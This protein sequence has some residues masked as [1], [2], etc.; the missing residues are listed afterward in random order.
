MSAV[1]DHGGVMTTEDLAKHCSTFEEAIS[2]EYKGVRL[3]EI[4]P[5]TQGIVALMAL[6]MLKNIDV[7]GSHM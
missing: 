3:W 1:I 6:S 7:K 2:V 4:P 5:N